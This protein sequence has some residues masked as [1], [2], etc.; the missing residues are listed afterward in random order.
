[1]AHQLG[2]TDQA[3]ALGT[4][5]RATLAE[6]VPVSWEAALDLVADKLAAAVQATG[7]DSV[8]SLSSARC[9]NEDNYVFQKLM[10]ATIGTNN[11]DHCARLCHAST[12]SGLAMAFGGGAMTNSIHEIRDADCLFVTGSNTTE[13]H[14]VISYEMGRAGKSGPKSGISLPPDS[15]VSTQKVFPERRDD[16][17]PG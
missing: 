14:P 1:M 2:L 9:T 10:R 7:P 3:W 11:V 4:T 17:C 6:C 8:A 15:R 13:S 5:P 12:V 16:L